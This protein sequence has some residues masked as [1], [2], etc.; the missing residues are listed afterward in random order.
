MSA[1]H[2]LV[3]FAQAATPTPT[4][5]Q[6]VKGG[7][8]DFPGWIVPAGALFGV[9]LNARFNRRTLEDMQKD[10]I[11]AEEQAETRRHA[12]EKKAEDLRVRRE[13][14]REREREAREERIA[15]A[16]EDREKAREQ[17]RDLRAEQAEKR[18]AI[19]AIR[20]AL[21]EISDIRHSAGALRNAETILPRLLK[22][23]EISREDAHL[24]ATWMRPNHFARFM[25]LRI[26]MAAAGLFDKPIVKPDTKA[27]AMLE[28]VYVGGTRAIEIGREEVTRLWMEIGDENATSVQWTDLKPLVIKEK[29]AEQGEEKPRV[30]HSDDPPSEGKDDLPP[31]VPYG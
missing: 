6:V 16:R 22:F 14:L 25:D 24:M 29:A 12:R 2:A 3:T 15:A 20:L 5:V 26:A 8:S 27:L 10:R 19:A 18:R 13:E 21:H 30:G 11:K 1:F 4:P 7:G 9:W 17:E 28:Q 23:R 31:D